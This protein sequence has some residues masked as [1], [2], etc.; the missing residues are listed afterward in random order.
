MERNLIKGGLDWYEDR[1]KYPRPQHLETPQPGIGV[2]HLILQFTSRHSCTSWT[3][4]K[5]S[6]P[7]F[8]SP[9][10][11]SW[12]SPIGGGFFFTWFLT[13]TMVSKM[14]SWVSQCENIVSTSKHSVVFPCQDYTKLDSDGAFGL[15]KVFQFCLILWLR[16][17]V[18][19]ARSVKNGSC[20]KLQFVKSA[21]VIY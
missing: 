9:S 8:S 7:G 13:L 18:S 1:T 12:P 4:R 5:D 17:S 14:L 3:G 6:L 2:D 15:R 21:C 19:A 10:N 11:F 20:P 16:Y